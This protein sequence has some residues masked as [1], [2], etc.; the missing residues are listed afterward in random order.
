MY[1]PRTSCRICKSAKNVEVDLKNSGY[2]KIFQTITNT[3][4]C[5]KLLLLRNR[6]ISILLFQ[7]KTL[8]FNMICMDCFN[9][10]AT[11]Q[12]F[13]VQCRES[14]EFFNKLEAKILIGD[15]ES[16]FQVLELE[17]SFDFVSIKEEA[18]GDEDYSDFKPFL[19]PE[20]IIKPGIKLTARPTAKKIQIRKKAIKEPCFECDYCHRLFGRKDYLVDHLQTHIAR[21]LQC[22]MCEGWYKGV[23]CLRI[24]LRKVHKMGWGKERKRMLTDADKESP[25]FD[26]AAA[27]ISQI[28]IKK[29][30]SNSTIL[31]SCDIC[32]AI[33]TRK[34]SLVSHV[35]NVHFPETY[36]CDLCIKQFHDRKL[37]VRHMKKVHLNQ[38]MPS[39]R[40]CYLCNQVFDTIELLKEHRIKV[41]PK[42]SNNDLPSRI[43][44]PCHIC[45]NFYNR[46]T[47]QNH[48]KLQ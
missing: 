39:I 35:K 46:K 16:K 43:K 37:L 34:D 30:K 48:I 10:L 27:V 8:F 31:I 2:Y 38:I 23:N 11:M 15:N 21:K 24:H 1:E 6:V 17:D 47:I 36:Q 22:K 26:S 4:V 9:F 7:D 5:I 32:Q 13:F 18:L 29:P 40:K 25:T 44:V 42:G 28:R 33:F 3:K 41:H 19:E 14:N 20:T 12:D 45:G